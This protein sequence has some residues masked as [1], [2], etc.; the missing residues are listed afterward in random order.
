MKGFH[1]LPAEWDEKK[2]AGQEKTIVETSVGLTVDFSAFD[3][4][5]QICFT[6]AAKNGVVGWTL[7]CSIFRLDLQISTDGSVIL[8]QC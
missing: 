3:L 4:A 1:Y 5:P 8:R 2:G 7:K 6:A